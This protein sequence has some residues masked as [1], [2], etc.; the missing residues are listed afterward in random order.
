MT[1]PVG[2]VFRMFPQL[3][4]TFVANEVLELERLGI[5]L[6]LYS[7]RTPRADV[8]HECVRLI[9][10][11]VSYLPDPIGRAPWQLLRATLACLRRDPVRYQSVV[12]WVLA[13]TL[14]ARN[15]DTWRRF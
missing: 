6:R 1:R 12:R 10:E 5:P 8:P 2:Y 15:P 14:R 11:P 9:R 13:K 7:Y 4:E 3:S